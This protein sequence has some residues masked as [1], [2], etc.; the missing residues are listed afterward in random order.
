M[1]AGNDDDRGRVVEN[2]E[3]GD[4]SIDVLRAGRPIGGQTE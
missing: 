2:D 3:A 1:V 4:V